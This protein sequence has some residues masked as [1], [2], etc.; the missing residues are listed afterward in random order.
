MTVATPLL[1]DSNALIALTSADHL[2]HSAVLEYFNQKPVPFATCPITQGALLRFHLRLDP[3]T[4]APRAHSLLHAL[5]EHPRHH[6]WPDDL[7]YSA[8]RGLPLRG[9]QQVTDFYLAAL[10][11]SKSTRL[12]TLDRSLAAHRPEACLLLE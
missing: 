9:H 6:F 8:L 11:L 5:G 2:S 12:L 4:G 3:S 10:A 1:L 7:P